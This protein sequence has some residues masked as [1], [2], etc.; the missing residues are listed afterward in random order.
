MSKLKNRE[1]DLLFEA[2][3][4]LKNL[5]ECYLFF[6]DTCTIKE[7]QSIS[8]RFDVA[9]KMDAGKNYKEVIEETGAS[10]ATISRVNRC[11]NYGDGGYKIAIER[12]KE[13]GKL[14]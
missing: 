6:E 7:I 5:E 8:Q 14:E 11:I 13:A 10:S 1:T 2:I 9:C 12:L 3:L 4:T